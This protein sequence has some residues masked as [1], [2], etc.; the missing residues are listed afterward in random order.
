M[1]YTKPKRLAITGGYHGVHMSLNIYKLGRDNGI[2]II[3]IDDPYKEGDIV[4]LET[5]LNP[6]GESR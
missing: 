2:E 5:P 1:V 4:W 3:D 6:T